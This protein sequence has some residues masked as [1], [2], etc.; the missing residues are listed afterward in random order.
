MPIEASRQQIQEF[1][2]SPRSRT[3]AITGEWGSGK[4]Y[5]W[6]QVLYQHLQDCDL[7]QYAYVSCF[8]IQT[9]PDLRT[10]LFLRTAP[11]RWA[12]REPSW[13]EVNLYW[14]ELKGRAA[15][16]VGRVTNLV[17]KAL[18]RSQQV[19]VSLEALA[20]LAL[21]NTLVCLDDVE[22]SS[23][24]IDQLLGIVS[25]LKEKRGC[26]IVLIFN[27]QAMGER[28][29]M[30]AQ[31]QEKVVDLEV[32]LRTTPSEAFDIVFRDGYRS[33]AELAPLVSSLGATNIR[34]LRQH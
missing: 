14:P 33:K 20:T 27:D 22:R 15:R 26:R 30:Y 1:L 34:V 29:A 13:I 2:T 3:L 19:A 31:Y 4:T 32:R 18:G 16:L 11:K 5:L 6:N 7:D 21:K 24:P 10:A 8:G 9:A 12:L 23:V 25:E 17:G 28:S